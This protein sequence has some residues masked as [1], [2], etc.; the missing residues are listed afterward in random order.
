MIWHNLFL[1]NQYEKT[2]N[3]ALEIIGSENKLLEKEHCWNKK[4]A[5]DD[6]SSAV[7]TWE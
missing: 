7:R 1:L 4:N 6:L 3:G 2:V 5:M